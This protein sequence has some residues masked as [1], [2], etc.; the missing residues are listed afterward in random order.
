MKQITS[1]VA[2]LFVVL[3]LV[4]G[5]VA[6]GVISPVGA[7]IGIDTQGNSIHRVRANGIDIAYKLI[8]SGE[9]LVLLMGLGGTMEQWPQ[10]V[11]DLLSQQYQLILLDNRGMGFSTVNDAPFS[12]KL[13]ADDIV[14]LLDALGV[15][16]ANV[17]GYSLGSTMTQEL[18]YEYPQRVNKAVIY[19]TAVDGSNVAKVL[20]GVKISNPIIARY[21]E[22]TAHWKTPMEK[23][24]GITNP[25]LFVVGTADAVVGPESSKLLA[26]ALPGAWLAQ[27]TNATHRLMFEA[28]TAFAH[29]VLA[30]LKID[31][32][33]QPQEAK[34]GARP[35]AGQEQP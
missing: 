33:V 3:A 10:A 14:G 24:A 7:S 2:S 6:A 16:K 20:G 34:T 9:P 27:F 17:L 28:P 22:A 26:T 15:S 4:T 5:S 11:I 30:F 31:A 18:L 19:A 13:F 35:T 12:Y 8:G 32:T 25:V 1:C 29:T 21:V 23:L